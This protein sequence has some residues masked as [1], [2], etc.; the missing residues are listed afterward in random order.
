MQIADMGVVRTASHHFLIASV[1]SKTQSRFSSI[2][3][4]QEWGAIKNKDP[5]KYVSGTHGFGIDNFSYY[6]LA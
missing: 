1:P 6:A 4:N 2:D 3:G 5:E